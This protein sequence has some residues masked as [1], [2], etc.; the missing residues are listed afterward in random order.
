[1]N[2]KMNITRQILPDI[3]LEKGNL[4]EVLDIIED[5]YVVAFPMKRKGKFKRVLVNEGEGEL[6]D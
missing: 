4:Y 5:S 2:L 3:T 6:V 1:M